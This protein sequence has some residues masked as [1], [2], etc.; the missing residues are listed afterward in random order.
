MV[1]P[2]VLPRAPRNSEKTYDLPVEYLKVELAPPL[3]LA[4]ISENIRLLCG[5]ASLPSRPSDQGTYVAMVSPDCRCTRLAQSESVQRRRRHG[6]G[7]ERAGGGSALA[8]SDKR[9]PL[10]PSPGSV[11]ASRLWFSR[12]VSCRARSWTLYLVQM[13]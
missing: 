4:S 3:R 7:A 2:P 13:F 10:V 9:P 12:Y 8:K 1:L 6:G 5:L 11:R